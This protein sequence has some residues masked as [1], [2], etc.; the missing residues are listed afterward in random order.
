MH[1]I[2]DERVYWTSIPESGREQIS[3]YGHEGDFSL[4]ASPFGSPPYRRTPPGSSLRSVQD[5]KTS[6]PYP[7]L[8]TLF[9]R[10]V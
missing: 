5:R 4:N 10:N 9:L 3:C 6:T 1:D 2:R 8:L 7:R